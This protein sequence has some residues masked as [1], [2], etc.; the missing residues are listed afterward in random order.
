MITLRTVPSVVTLY[1]SSG[2][3]LAEGPPPTAAQRI[4]WAGHSHPHDVQ[5]RGPE[6]LLP[7]NWCSPAGSPEPAC[8]VWE[9]VEH[10]RSG[11][12][13]Q[14]A[15]VGDDEDPT[16]RPAVAVHEDERRRAHAPEHHL[17]HR[18]E[19]ADRTGDAARA[20]PPPGGVGHLTART[21]P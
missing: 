19:R 12:R 8:S 4:L 14:P 13:H 20:G 21:R 1:T 6:R 7:A 2:F 18:G 3:V 9:A 16:A 10:R 5:R 11:A 17:P 15:V